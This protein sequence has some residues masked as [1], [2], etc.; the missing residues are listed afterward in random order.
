MVSTNVLFG[1]NVVGEDARVIG[2]STGAEIDLSSMQG[3]DVI[4]IRVRK[5]LAPAGAWVNHDEVQYSGAQPTGHPSVHVNPIPDVYGV[6]IAMR[7]TAGVLRTIPCEFTDA[8][9]LGMP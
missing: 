8:K 4:S 5:V 1:K 9:R 6:E 7:Q 2:E 3:G